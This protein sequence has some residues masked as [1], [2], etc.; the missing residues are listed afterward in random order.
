MLT[1]PLIYSTFKSADPES[2]SK[3]FRFAAV[4]G[5][6]VAGVVLLLLLLLSYFLWR[7]RQK[8]KMLALVSHPDYFKT[9]KEGKNYNY[10]LSWFWQMGLHNLIGFVVSTSSILQFGAQIFSHSSDCLSK[11]SS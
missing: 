7:A 11:S 8:T 4:V 9:E 2:S 10:Q 1:F 6:A 3:K 5:A